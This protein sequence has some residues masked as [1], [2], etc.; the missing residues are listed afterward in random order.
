MSPGNRQREVTAWGGTCA[1]PAGGARARGG[2]RRGALGQGQQDD[3]GRGGH[4]DAGDEQPEV[5]A[6][7]E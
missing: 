1:R 6:R 5:H 2:G 7:H 3:A 4:H